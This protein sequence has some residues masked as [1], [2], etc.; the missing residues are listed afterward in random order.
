VNRT[1][2]LVLSIPTI[3]YELARRIPEIENP[4]AL[5][6]AKDLWIFDLSLDE[7][8]K[9]LIVDPLQEAS[10]IIKGNPYRFPQLFL[11]HGLEDCDDNDF[12]ELFLRAF[13]KSLTLL[14]QSIPQKLILLGRHTAHVQECFERPEMRGVVQHRPLPVHFSKDACAV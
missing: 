6:A 14:Q 2:H 5:M 8:M 4:I 12:Q 1:T 3:A 10:I 7:Q 13:G 9:K 11:I